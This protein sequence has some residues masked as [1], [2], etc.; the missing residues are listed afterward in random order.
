MAKP[1]KIFSLV[2]TARESADADGMGM[3][4][5]VN[6]SNNGQTFAHLTLT[7]FTP[8]ECY[9]AKFF[10]QSSCSFGLRFDSVGVGSANGLITNGAG[11]AHGESGNGFGD[12][13][14]DG[15]ALIDVEVWWDPDCDGHVD[16]D[17]E[18][19]ATGSAF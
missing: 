8:N 10:S 19:A 1:I 2:P 14:C 5:F 11:N 16:T 15:T 17:G 3:L 18:L 9:A 13:T 7:G 6:N 4:N 12:A